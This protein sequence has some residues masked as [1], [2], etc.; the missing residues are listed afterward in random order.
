MIMFE[1]ENGQSRPHLY[2]YS[3]GRQTNIHPHRLHHIGATW[4]SDPQHLWESRFET[5]SYLLDGAVRIIARNTHGLQA[6]RILLQ[7]S[8]LQAWGTSL[9][10]GSSAIIVEPLCDPKHLGSAWAVSSHNRTV[11]IR[12]LQALHHP[13]TKDRARHPLT[14]SAICRDQQSWYPLRSL[15]VPVYD[16]FS[17]RMVYSDRSDTSCHIMDL[18]V[19][20]A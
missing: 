7:R 3:G 16:V 19:P 1:E 10:N 15:D 20:P 12:R 18:L 14:L 6:V 8:Q 11:D 9:G 2:S 13:L 4:T 5:V 17:H